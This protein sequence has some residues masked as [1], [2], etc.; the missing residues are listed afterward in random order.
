MQS[1][2]PKVDKPV[3]DHYNTSDLIALFQICDVFVL[4]REAEAFGIAAVEASA[5]GLP[6]I[7]TA[8]GGLT[9]IVVDM[10][11]QPCMVSD[12]HDAISQAYEVEPEQ[13]E[14]DLQELLQR[15]IAEKLIEVRY[16]EAAHLPAAL[17]N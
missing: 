17:S 3:S 12:L 10:V 14:E 8:G 15:L 11:Q 1:A 7:A 16:V 5:A 2:K 9:D 13:C 4:P 6:V